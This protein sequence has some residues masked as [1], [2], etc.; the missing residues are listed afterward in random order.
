MRVKK[1]TSG[2]ISLMTVACNFFEDQRPGPE[3][4]GFTATIFRSKLS[5]T[6]E[7]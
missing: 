1:S 3:N 4:R 7:E 2:H 6:T 5:N